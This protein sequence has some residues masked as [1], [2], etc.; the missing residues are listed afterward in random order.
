MEGSGLR[1]RRARF[2]NETSAGL[3][4]WPSKQGKNQILVAESQPIFSSPRHHWH[5]IL[6]NV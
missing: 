2:R 1:D 4:R 6:I 3:E 5:H